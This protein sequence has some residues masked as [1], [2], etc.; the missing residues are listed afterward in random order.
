MSIQEKIA[1]DLEKRKR[2]NKS[3]FI[4]TA[5]FGLDGDDV[6]EELHLKEVREILFTFSL[7]DLKKI[8][9][10]SVSKYNVCCTRILKDEQVMKLKLDTML[11]RTIIY[12]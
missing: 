7:E 5:I 10:M 6:F 3:E 1:Q 4:H 11:D 9:F 12:V 2:M 8:G